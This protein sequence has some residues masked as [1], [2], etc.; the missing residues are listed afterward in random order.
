[1]EQLT[2]EIIVDN[3]AGGGGASTGIELATGRSVDIAIN[4][5]SEA[6]AMHKTN[7]PNTEH[8]EESVWDINPREVC[9]GRAVALGWFSPDCTH[10][11]KA[12]GSKPVEKSIRGL[13]WV[14][15]R[16]GM[17]VT[18]RVIMLENVEEFQ[19]WGPLLDNG[20]PDKQRRGETYEGFILALTTG[21]SPRHPAYEECIVALGLQWDIQARRK[22]AKGLGYTVDTKMWRAYDCGT[23][24]IRNR[25]FLI[26]RCDKQPIVWPKPTHGNPDSLPVKAGKLKPYRTIAEFLDF[27]HPCP[28]IFERKRPLVENTLR[29]IA[30]GIQRYVIDDPNPFIISYYGPKNDNEFRG[31]GLDQPLP[32]QTTENR[33][34]L[35]APHITEHANA[36]SQ[37]NMP[38]NEPMRTLCAQVK[39]GHFALTSGFIAKHYTGVVGSSLLKPLPTV[40]T[41]DH[42]S[43]A[44]C[45]IVKFR[46]G[47]DGQSANEPLHTITSGGGHFGE[48]RGS[49]VKYYGTGEGQSLNEPIHTVTTKD[50]FGLNLIKTIK[51]PFSDDVLYDAWWIA[52]FMED[53]TDQEPLR[54]SIPYERK[55]WINVGD[56]AILHDLGMRMLQP[57][58]LYDASGF[59]HDYIIDHDYTGKKITKTSQVARCGNAVPPPFAEHLVRANLPE[60]CIGGDFY[61]ANSPRATQL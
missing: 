33:F 27:S 35:V 45:S 9:D 16:W 54:T 51:P 41:I 3:F 29:R 38:A 6:I 24:T 56:N 1:M 10:F 28:S 20:K 53:Y 49:L 30:K 4:H 25:F 15:V 32:T 39:G 18:P 42:N 26:A 2:R 46:N 21:L 17:D 34:G 19:T 37:R 44:T 57:R 43:L 7:H 48:L 61:D 11:S 14:T 55:H 59:P 22:I 8:Y 50:R 52:R 58:E 36:S 13:A 31:I 12:K 60:M 47:C 23:G 5:N 40:T